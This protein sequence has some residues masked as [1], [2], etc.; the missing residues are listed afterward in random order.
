MTGG[1]GEVVF[2]KRPFRIFLDLLLLAFWGFLGVMFASALF[3]EDPE[4]ESRMS[5]F[6]VA[7]IFVG[8]AFGAYYV[9]K[10]IFLRGPLLRVTPEGFHY[11][12]A[13]EEFTPWSNVALVDVERS[14]RWTGT[15]TI[16][17]ILHEGGYIDIECE[18]FTLKL[19]QVLDAFRPYCEIW[20]Q[21]KGF[22]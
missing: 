6:G 20:E 4:I 7:V 15:S 11:A 10:V 5:W 1:K 17:V 2:R 9:I 19:D 16:S 13:D 8:V 12:L 22:V 18:F 3:Y 21:P 14:R